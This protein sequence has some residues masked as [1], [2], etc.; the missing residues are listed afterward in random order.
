MAF[1]SD[2]YIVQACLQS[3]QCQRCF[4]FAFAIYPAHM[5]KICKER[6]LIQKQGYEEE[7]LKTHTARISRK[8]TSIALKCSK[9]KE[10]RD[11][12]EEAMDK[13]D[14]DADNCLSKM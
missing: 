8:A 2:R 3:L 1:I 11:L 12:L 6:I 10:L 7:S 5:D 4:H 9:S 13:L 14:L